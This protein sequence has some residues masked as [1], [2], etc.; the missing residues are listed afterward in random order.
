MDKDAVAGNNIWG[1]V[2]TAGRS[3]RVWAMTII[4]VS[5]AIILIVVFFNAMLRY[6][7]AKNYVELGNERVITLK[8]AAGSRSISK[9]K[10]KTEGGKAEYYITYKPGVVSEADI[11]L[12]TTALEDE[13]YTMM[14]KSKEPYTGGTL[15]LGKDTKDEHHVV[16]VTLLYHDEVLSV[17]YRRL[18]GSLGSEFG[19]RS[20]SP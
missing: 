18:T 5:V 19:K 9:Y 6:T 2:K 10:F 12:Y 1:I 20:Q 3:R 17:Q 15:T 14:H 8:Y 7:E 11:W 4:S 13:G 16:L